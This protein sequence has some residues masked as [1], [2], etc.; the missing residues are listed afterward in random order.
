[1]VQ[2][3]TLDEARITAAI[4]GYEQV[5]PDWMPASG[6]EPL[7]LQDPALVWL[8]YHGPKHGLHP[9]RSDYEFLDFIAEKA[10]QF[11]DKWIKEMAPDAV[12]VCTHGHEVRSADRVRQTLDLMGRGVPVLVQPAL[13]WAPERIYGR[14]DV[15]I[16][17]CWLAQRF[18]YLAAELGT[19]VDGTD[20]VPAG[21]GHY[22]VFDM[23]F[24]SKLDGSHKALELESYA[25]QVRLYSYMLGQ[26]QGI[27]PQAGY[28]ITRDRILNPLPVEITSTLDRPLDE[29]LASSRDQFIEIKTNGARY[30]PWQDP[31][32]ASNV[33][34]RDTQWYT[35]K[36]II[37]RDKT[38]GR[39]PALV[40]RI[41]PAI[42]RELVRYG[43]GTLD[44]LLEGDP[45]EIPFEACNNLGEVSSRQIRAM[46]QANR[47]GSPAMPGSV[48]TL[49]EKEFE[50]Y[51]DF[52]YFTNINVDFEAQWPT[53][54]GCEMIFMVGVG[55]QEDGARS[56]QTFVSEAEDRDHEREMLDNFLE[57]LQN[58]TDGALEDGDKT[59]LFH[60]TDAEV[61]QALRASNRHQF[62]ETH[63]LR[64]LPWRDL[65]KEFLHGPIGLPGAWSYRLKD[66]SRALS[67]LRPDLDLQWP[68]DLDQGLRAMVMGWKA[69]L[70]PEPLESTEMGL[71]KEYLEADCRA[72]WGI[73]KWL[74]SW[75]A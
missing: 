51:V 74:R 20:Q 22:V 66:V 46:L 19:P 60:W 5:P 14:P 52:E 17:T 72:L 69:Y 75:A 33:S 12:R 40:S 71:L 39:D 24:T 25:A 54:D 7:I 34:H 65:H 73:L 37:A 47:S 57:F 32:V 3:M 31:I 23:K 45:D 8:R 56:F 16:H 64:R 67:Q 68:G 11:E 43:F 48:P 28:L 27:M 55:W 9:D 53:L 42:R 41:S 63:P 13:W 50:F 59:S 38:P 21:L 26:L 10:Q 30:V 70:A 58:R 35:A 2:G 44:S 49:P 4:G 18:P 29:G 15:L 62:P 1:M 36:K 61:W 6:V